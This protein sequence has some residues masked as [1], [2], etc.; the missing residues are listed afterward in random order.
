[1]IENNEL[2]VWSEVVVRVVETHWRWL[3]TGVLF[4]VVLAQVRQIILGIR[5]WHW[6]SVRG[7][8]TDSRI[9]RETDSEGTPMYS[10]RVAYRYQVG[11][12]HFRG[13]RIQ[14]GRNGLSSSWRGGAQNLVDSFPVGR[15]VPIYHHPA[16]PRLSTLLPGVSSWSWFF[17][18]VTGAA[19]AWFLR[20]AWLGPVS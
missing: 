11:G 18:V 16:R 8:V 19:S 6:P 10:A 7:I 1:M 12:K 3:L 5:A 17:L 13:R 2:V 4:L 15:S 20:L 14:F 9:N